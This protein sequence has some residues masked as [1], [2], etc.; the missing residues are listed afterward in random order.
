MS[1]LIHVTAK[2]GYGWPVEVTN[3][4]GE[5]IYRSQTKVMAPTAPTEVTD[6]EGNVV[7]EISSEPMAV[8]NDH[9]IKLADGREA[10]VSRKSYAMKHAASIKGYGWQLSGDAKHIDVLNA[11]TQNRIA[12]AERVMTHWSFDVEMFDEVQTLAVVTVLISLT[13]M[14]RKMNTATRG[15]LLGSGE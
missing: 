10:E 14:F 13:Q 8:E 11:A 7:A 5:L 1:A 3:G 15:M 9:Y 4:E 6:A 12:H 2:N